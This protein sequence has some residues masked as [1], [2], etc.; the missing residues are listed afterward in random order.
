MGK[1]HAQDG[2]LDNHD[3]FYFQAKAVTV[4]ELL[5]RIHNEGLPIRLVG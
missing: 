1:H 5:Q 2:Y 4:V 3:N